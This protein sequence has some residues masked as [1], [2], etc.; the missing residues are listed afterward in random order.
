MV[1]DVREEGGEV[2]AVLGTASP[3]VVYNEASEPVA[4]KMATDT[5]IRLVTMMWEEAIMSNQE[6]ETAEQEED[7]E[8]YSRLLREAIEDDDGT[9]YTIEDLEALHLALTEQETLSGE[10]V[11]KAEAAR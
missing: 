7:E 5:K 9:R 2:D 6:E 10:A 1:C 3:G 8:V 11:L 4:K